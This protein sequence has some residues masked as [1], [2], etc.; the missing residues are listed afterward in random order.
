METVAVYSL[1]TMHSS[2]IQYTGLLHAVTQSGAQLL[3]GPVEADILM[4]ILI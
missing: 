2:M 3:E 1:D 4:F